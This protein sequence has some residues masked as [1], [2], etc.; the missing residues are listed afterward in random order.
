[1]DSDPESGAIKNNSISQLYIQSKAITDIK[2]LILTMDRQH[3]GIE[4][5]VHFLS[6]VTKYSH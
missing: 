2:L 4:L 6:H 1:M 5:L 3:S